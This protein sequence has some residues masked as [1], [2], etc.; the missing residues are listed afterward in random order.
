MLKSIETACDKLSNYYIVFEVFDLI[1][2]SF[3]QFLGSLDFHHLRLL[4]MK[5][6]SHFKFVFLNAVSEI[7]TMIELQSTELNTFIRFQSQM[8]KNDRFSSNRFSLV[9]SIRVS[10]LQKEMTFMKNKQNVNKMLLLQ[11]SKS[12]CPQ[13]PADISA[14]IAHYPEI[15]GRV[16]CAQTHVRWLSN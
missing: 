13:L 15:W 4:Q 12:K 10:G 11:A 9:L 1:E 16:G 7:H 6:I 3:K 14:D 8:K 2:Q 5:S